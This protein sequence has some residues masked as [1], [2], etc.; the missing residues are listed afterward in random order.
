MTGQIHQIL[1]LFKNVL[2]EFFVHEI[3]PGLGA[4]AALHS[5]GYV[6]CHKSCFYGEG[7]GSA[8]RVRQYSVLVPGSETDEGGGQILGD[9]SLGRELAVATLM[10]GFTCGVKTYG[11]H[12]FFNENTK[13]VFGS[14][15]QK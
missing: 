4:E 14:V 3:V 5:R 11:H 2:P 1:C 6:G 13:R 7:S 8:K 12:V 15:F 9:G 10:Q